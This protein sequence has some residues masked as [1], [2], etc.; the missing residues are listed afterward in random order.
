M[1]YV[2]SD[3]HSNLKVS[4]FFFKALLDTSA[5]NIFIFLQVIDGCCGHDNLLLSLYK[6]QSRTQ[7]MPVVKILSLITILYK[8]IFFSNNISFACSES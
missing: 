8:L 2:S 1:K 3:R 5:A 6:L 4:V 7:C